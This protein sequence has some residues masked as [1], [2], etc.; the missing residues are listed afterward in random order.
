MFKTN[1]RGSH[2]L[3]R[4]GAAQAL[5]RP[6][7]KGLVEGRAP[8]TCFPQGSRRFLGWHSTTS[9]QPQCLASLL[10][11]GGG[12]GALPPLAAVGQ[13]PRGL[14]R[15][16]AGREVRCAAW[17]WGFRAWD[18]VVR[19]CLSPPASF[20]ARP[21]PSTGLSWQS[22][23]VTWPRYGRAWAGPRATVGLGR[24]MWAFNG[25]LGCCRSP[26]SPW[27]GGLWGGRCSD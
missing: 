12:R 6:S 26:G 3:P 5:H 9:T 7:Q 15:G 21:W 8:K 22:S 27:A 18:T 19:L 24:W 25:D 16:L 14:W 10:C 11:R 2:I 17:G 1:T 13:A 23:S 20:S 4:A